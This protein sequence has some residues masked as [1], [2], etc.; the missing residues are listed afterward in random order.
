MDTSCMERN[1]I[2]KLN[3]GGVR[4]STSLATLTAAENSYFDALFSGR[5]QQHLTEEG[6]VFLDRDGE[7]SLSAWIEPL[8]RNQRSLRPT[9]GGTRH[10]SVM[11]S[12]RSAVQELP[13]SL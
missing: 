3:V 6:E 2:I 13:T 5:W 11:R 9:V 7:V 12:I 4:Y 1:K 10:C 8:A